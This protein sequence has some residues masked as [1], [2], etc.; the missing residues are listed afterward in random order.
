[1]LRNPWGNGFEWKLD[2]SDYDKRMTKEVRAI[3]GI[4][5]DLNDGIFCMCMSDYLKY[6]NVTSVCAIN[7]TND[8]HTEVHTFEASKES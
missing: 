5:K 8:T 4:K 7:S 2:Y 1:M 6:F 3:L